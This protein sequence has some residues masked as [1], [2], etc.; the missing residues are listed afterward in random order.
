MKREPKLTPEQVAAHV[1][2]CDGCS[3]CQGEWSVTLLEGVLQTVRAVGMFNQSA[4][5]NP[6]IGILEEAIKRESAKRSKSATTKPGKVRHNSRQEA[7]LAASKTKFTE[8]PEG[9]ITR[10]RL[11]ASRDDHIRATGNAHGWLKIA[12]LHFGLT[13][14]T[15]RNRIK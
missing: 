9:E 11:I 4:P 15:I 10:E 6:A 12:A 14:K 3:L 7:K 5:P 13:E 2:E 1:A 8:P